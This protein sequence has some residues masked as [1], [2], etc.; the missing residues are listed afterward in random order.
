MQSAHKIHYTRVENKS[1]RSTILLKMIA[2]LAT[3]T[4]ATNLDSVES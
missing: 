4:A 1:S 3:A 2:F